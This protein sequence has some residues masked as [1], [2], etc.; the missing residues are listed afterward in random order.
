MASNNFINECKNGAFANRLGKII[1]DGIND[2]ITNSDN[3]KKFTIDSGCYVD[4]DIIGSIY[5]KQLSGEFVGYTNTDNLIDKEIDAQIGVKYG[6]NTTE[7]ISMGKY[8][9][10]RPNEEKTANKAEITAYDNLINKINDKYVCGIEYGNNTITLEDLYVDVCDNL[11]L[12]PTT[13]NFLNNDIPITADPFTNGET[14]YTVL[15]TV[16]KISC[17]FVTIDNDSDEINLSWLSESETPD[18]IFYQSDYSTLEGGIIEFGPINSVTIKN[19]QVDS[20]NVTQK[21]DE[22]IAENG[23]HSIVIE[24][25]YILYNSSLRT[26][27]LPAIFNRLKDLK[28]VDSKLITYYGKPFLNIGDKIRI[29]QDNNSNLFDF[30]RTISVGE[31]TT[32]DDDGWI[33]TIFDNTSGDSHK[34]K[35]YTGLMDLKPDTNYIIVLEVSSSSGDGSISLYGSSYNESC[36]QIGNAEQLINIR[37]ASQRSP[38]ITNVR[39]RSSFENITNGLGTYCFIPNNTMCSIKYRISVLEDTSITPEIFQYEPY[40]KYI[41]TYV[42]K[43][44]FTYDGTFMSTIES[45][46]LTEQEIKTSYNT[47]LN[48]A[49]KSTEIEV[50]KQ[51]Q[52]IT[53]LVSSITEQNERIST[54]NQK[55]NR[56]DLDVR[57]KISEDEII[58]KLN[59]A[60]EDGQGIINITGNQVTIDSDNFQLTSDGSLTCNNGIFNGTINTGSGTIGGFTINSTNLYA[61]IQDKYSYTNEDFAILRSLL[62]SGASPTPEQLDKYDINRNGYLDIWDRVILQWKL[63]GD[64]STRGSFKIAAD[65]AYNTISF[66]GNANEKYKTVIGISQIISNWIFGSQIRAMS[67]DETSETVI[68]GTSVATPVL[69][70]TSLS[71]RKKN[72]ERLENAKDILKC[73]DIYKYNLQNEKDNDKKSIGFVIGDGFKYS[74]DI[75]SKDNEGVNIYSMISVLWQVVKE[76]QEEIEKLN[77]EIQ[78]IK[79]VIK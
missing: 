41:D 34:E 36:S 7:Y 1:V 26:R 17:S 79:G 25:D 22:N 5:I 54:I 6:D 24:E 72:F 11:G 23:E 73:V 49:L 30:K 40:P 20:E 39:T 53:S 61:N 18:Y 10:E 2:P 71:S 46:V 47:T 37:N 48:D 59:V 19:S 4:G 64:V 31:N 70:Q 69:Y 50:N 76:Q 42:L 35:F 21:D 38:I 55:A 57:E 77:E 14:N 16:A 12:T 8:T 33:T 75:T 3:L 63:L 43:H 58:A 68:T 44:N 66:E 29:M 45:P 56:I 62:A 13:T 60:I 51:K 27:A 15:Q 32:V 28:Y 74:E 52:T 9:I 78:K 65:E 67:D